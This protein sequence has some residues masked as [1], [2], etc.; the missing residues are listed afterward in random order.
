MNL[1]VGDKIKV[2]GFNCG[3]CAEQRFC[4]MGIICGKELEILAMQ[5]LHG[6]VT[7]KIGKADISIGRGMWNKIEYEVIE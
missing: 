5:P 2:T 7:F 3:E 6:P 4:H 1:K